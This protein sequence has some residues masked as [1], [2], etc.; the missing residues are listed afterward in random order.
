MTRIWIRSITTNVQYY[1]LHLYTY[2]HTCAHYTV[3]SRSPLALLSSYLSSGL[4]GST[5]L[6]SGVGRD[7]KEISWHL[8]QLIRLPYWSQRRDVTR[9]LLACLYS[10]LTICPVCPPSANTLNITLSHLPYGTVC[11]MHYRTDQH[12][13][14]NDHS[15]NVAI[16]L[17][18]VLGDA[19]F[20]YR[21]FCASTIDVLIAIVQSDYCD[22]PFLSIWNGHTISQQLLV[23]CVCFSPDWEASITGPSG[24]TF[25]WQYHSY[26]L[27]ASLQCQLVF[28]C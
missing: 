20:W 18:C 1:T 21:Y 2:I 19:N 26:G 27:T 28:S 16:Y 15:I 13:S 12:W 3:D 24:E 10:I 22:H 14:P 7:C 4:V 17:V 5:I 9:W 23:I 6:S 8:T 25:I 11:P